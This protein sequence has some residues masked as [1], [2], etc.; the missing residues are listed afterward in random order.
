MRFWGIVEGLGCE[1]TMGVEAVVHRGVVALPT[2]ARSPPSLTLR[3]ARYDASHDAFLPG[4]DGGGVLTLALADDEHVAALGN[5]G[6]RKTG[7]M[8][9]F[10]VL[11]SGDSLT[12][13][14]LDIENST[15]EATG[16]I[17]LP[18]GEGGGEVCLECWVADGPTVVAR[19][20]SKVVVA[21]ER[22]EGIVPYME[23]ERHGRPK[24]KADM[25][26][27]SFQRMF[28]AGTQ[29]LCVSNISASN[30]APELVRLLTCF[31]ICTMLLFATI[32]GTEI[33]NEA[34]IRSCEILKF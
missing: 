22:Q 23:F 5:V 17:T 9:T 3:T 8:C 1:A 28:V 25:L 13:G 14:K 7:L 20:P 2:E 12:I 10:L 26:E 16:A 11:A 27:G 15:Y 30:S 19:Y 32:R 33:E 21:S 31:S 24:W 29:V 18:Q 34:C 4:D 6:C